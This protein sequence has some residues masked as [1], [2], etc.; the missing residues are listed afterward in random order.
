M[1][2]T[3]P[4]DTFVR[5]QLLD[6]ASLPPANAEDELAGSEAAGAAEPPD[7]HTR[8]EATDLLPSPADPV[9]DR[10][11][12]AFL[13][14]RTLRLAMMKVIRGRVPDADI[15]DVVQEA[16]WAVKRAKRLPKGAVD[17]RRYALAIARNLAKTWFVRK[18]AER[19]EEVSFEDACWRISH[20]GGIECAIEREHLQK[21]EATVP[22]TQRATFECLGRYLLGENLAEMAREM[23]LEYDTLYK[24][25]TK[26]HR[27]LMK[28]GQAIAG[29]VV[30]LLLL[31]G[32]RRGGNVATPAPKH[33]TPK[34]EHHERAPKTSDAK[35]HA[36]ELREQ[37]RAECDAKQWKKCLASYDLAAALDPDGETPDVEAARKTALEGSRR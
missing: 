22:D 9:T 4:T 32:L 28:T 30:V 18:C 15:E 31:M 11:V 1:P 8:A 13:A 33:E 27:D 29:L 23:G 12:D 35:A 37:A 25:V 21:I 5:L 6:L 19:L 17:R 16:L 20:D 34:V 10:E 24:R 7:V 36:T 14:H 3:D 2:T 26:L